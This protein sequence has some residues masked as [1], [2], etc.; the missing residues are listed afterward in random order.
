[1]N[2]SSNRQA[3]ARVRAWVLEFKLKPS[4]A[5]AH[6][7]SPSLSLSLNSSLNLKRQLRP[8]RNSH[9]SQARARV[10]S[11]LAGRLAHL[12]EALGAI[13]FACTGRQRASAGRAAAIARATQ[14]HQIAVAELQR[15]QR[16]AE[17]RL[18]LVARIRAPEYAGRCDCASACCSSAVSQPRVSLDLFWCQRPCK[19][20]VKE[21]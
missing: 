15:R 9:I 12:V 6:L 1:M 18:K 20:G 4:P 8:W 7:E 3:Q 16:F 13:P 19:R 10:V 2:L 14:T 5:Q 21:V 17:R 11:R